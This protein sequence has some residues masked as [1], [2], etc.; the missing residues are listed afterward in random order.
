MCAGEKD[1][2]LLQRRAGEALERARAEFQ[3]GLGGEG[4]AEGR[5]E[6]FFADEKMRDAAL[7]YTWAAEM[8]RLQNVRR[9]RRLCLCANSKA[10]PAHA[11]SPARGVRCTVD[12][13]H[14]PS[15]AQPN[16]PP[17]E[18]EGG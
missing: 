17:A 1:E 13:R 18:R 16:P 7:D 9:P 12:A 3:Q 15:A 8:R 5:T 6:T 11:S 14:D 4:D 10:P 2:E